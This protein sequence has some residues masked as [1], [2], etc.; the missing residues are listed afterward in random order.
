MCN[1]K[2]KSRRPIIPFTKAHPGYLRIPVFGVPNLVL[3]PPTLKVFMITSS[4]S[5]RFLQTSQSSLSGCRNRTKGAIAFS[6]LLKENLPTPLSESVH[7]C[8]EWPV[9]MGAL[10]FIIPNHSPPGA[11]TS[12][13]P[14]DILHKSGPKTPTPGNPSLIPEVQQRGTGRLIVSKSPD[15][16]P[17][18]AP[19]DTFR[20]EGEAR[21]TEY[22][23]QFP[24]GTHASSA[25]DQDFNVP[26]PNFEGVT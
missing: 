23:N 3:S 1:F 7:P 18:T 16:A 26:V 14:R 17:T 2:P 5:L 15:P 8:Q 9:Q 13:Q 20:D 25:M 21:Q 12:P 10:F 24:V 6:H 22:L 19:M 11:D 4:L